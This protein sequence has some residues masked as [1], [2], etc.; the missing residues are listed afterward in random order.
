MNR[1]DFLISGGISVL[2][3]QLLAEEAT[4]EKSVIFIWLGGGASA[5][6][7]IN[8]LPNAPA[9]YRSINGHVLTNAGYELGGLFQKTAL[10][11][12]KITP[13]RSFRHA[14]N[15]H[16]SATHWVNTSYKTQQSATAKSIWPSYGSM[17][18][19]VYGTNKP[20]GMPTYIKL[21]N[22]R[23]D[24]A[25]WLGGAYTGYT[26]T[27]QGVKDLSLSIEEER[28]NQRI[29]I[30]EGI[31]SRAPQHFPK[32]WTDLREQAKE[33]LYGSVA[34]AFKVEQEP[35]HIRQLYN[36]DK[37]AFGK[38]CLTARRL[39]QNGAQF[40]TLT[41]NGWDMH[42]K[43]EDGMKNRMPSLDEG[44]AALIS[45]LYDQGLDKDCLVIMSSEFS[46]TKINANAGRDHNSGSCVLLFS[47]GGYNH[48]RVIGATA[49]DGLTAQEEVCQP[50]DLNKT[51][52]DHFN[53]DNS[54][55]IV[56]NDGRPH[57]VVEQNT[58][59]LL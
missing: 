28:F 10:L 7:L 25:A 43:I 54:L 24:G 29:Q 44:L 56:G 21:A 49:N 46:R 57:F 12:D 14:D 17:V 38:Q 34:D 45:D 23:H 3:S 5:V 30:V 35:E 31:E 8:P 41:H 42:S 16:D 1:R 26:A 13:V 4:K 52:V 20:D 19:Y 47:G 48:G 33:V 39:V 58:R 53:I 15:S 18:S 50:K 37:N 32:T 40:V 55:T 11:G 2:G 51:I 27:G 59:N 22:I 6:E 36:A 9:E